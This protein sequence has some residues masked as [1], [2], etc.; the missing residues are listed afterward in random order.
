LSSVDI[1]VMS[2]TQVMM[3]VVCDFEVTVSVRS[4][5]CSE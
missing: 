5:A 3:I 2:V 1:A 4:S